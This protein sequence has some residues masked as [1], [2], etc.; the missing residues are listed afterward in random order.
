MQ[1]TVVSPKAYSDILMQETVVSPKAYSDLLC[2]VLKHV[3]H[4]PSTR[5]IIS[6]AG[7]M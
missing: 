6:D 4:V 7:C 3:A 5:D 2:P 1:E